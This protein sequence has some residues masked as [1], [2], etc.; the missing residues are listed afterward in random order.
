MNS[1]LAIGLDPGLATTGYGIV[2]KTGGKLKALEW[3]VV[4]TQKNL[5][6]PERLHII[7]ADVEKL[8]KRF[9]PCVAV[10]ESI[11]FEKN[12]KTAINVAQARGVI[13]LALQKNRIKILEL[14]PMQLKSRITSYGGASKQQVQNMVKKLL[15]LG[16]IPKPDD[17]ADALSLAF[18][19][20]LTLPSL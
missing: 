2:S 1:N 17:A 15:E 19:G 7:H 3:G 9:K 20:T 8:V 4:E 16:D 11:F 10:V 18:C 13:L 6:L 12:L 14:T 5:P